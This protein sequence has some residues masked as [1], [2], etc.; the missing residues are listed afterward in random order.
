MF[1]LISD[2]VV[3]KNGEP[4]YPIHIRK[5]F[6][7][8]VSA[9]ESVYPEKRPLRACIVTD[10]NVSPL[11]LQPVKDLL[12]EAFDTVVSFVFPAG[13]EQK[14]LHTVQDLYE[15]LI[16]NRFDRS[17]ILVALGGGV[18]GD[19]CGFAASTYMRGIDFIQIPT[20]L[21]SQVDSSIGGKTGVD[22][23]GFKNMVGAFY[24]PRLV[25]I[26]VSVLSTLPEE[27]LLSGMG[28]VLKHGLIRDRAYFDMLSDNSSRILAKD[29]QALMEAVSGSCRI[30]QAVTEEDPYERGIRAILNFGHTIGHA[31]EGLA[32][33]TLPHGQC[34]VLGM[35][36]A[37]DLSVKYG[38]LSPADADDAIQVLASYGLPIQLPDELPKRLSAKQIAKATLADKKRAGKG[39]KFV[40]LEDIG[41]ASVTTR[42][43]DEDLRK[44]AARIFP[45][46]EA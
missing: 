41:N 37:L 35:V 21:L 44:A 13:E 34:V 10:S 8:L 15:V 30:K 42:V 23:R 38:G 6:S 32:D 26:N 36:C 31:V 2:F 39:L 22:F 29:P 14:N 9:I 17:D 11:Y 3:K 40:I 25:Y 28:E 19:L 7:D 20:T 46:G 24:M 45:E 27:Q 4:C 1:Q 16:A 12:A 18:T 33:F 5:D 43:T